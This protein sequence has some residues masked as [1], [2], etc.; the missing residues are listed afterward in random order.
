[1]STVER[2]RLSP[3]DLGINV[4]LLATFAWAF[5]EAGQWSFRASLFPQAVVGVGAALSLLR[6]LL[7]LRTF[8]AKSDE[9]PPSSSAPIAEE[10]GVDDIEYVFGH[11]T[12]SMWLHALGW[13]AAFYVGLWLVGLFVVTPVFSF[14]YLKLV[15][16]MRWWGALLY[17][18]IAWGLLHLAFGVLLRLRMPQGILW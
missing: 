7:V 17:A 8:L 6:L 10:E 1:M 15:A 16:K 4:A 12:M 3:T 2:A 5:V 13:I 18:G 9:P 11:A 14:V